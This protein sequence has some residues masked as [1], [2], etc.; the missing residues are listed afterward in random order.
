MRATSGPL[1][2]GSAA[3]TPPGAATLYPWRLA[4]TP[5][6]APAKPPVNGLVNATRQ[7]TPNQE[8]TSPDCGSSQ[9]QPAVTIRTG[10]EL[11]ETG[12]VGLAVKRFVGSS[13]IASTKI[14][15]ECWPAS[16]RLTR[17][18]SEGSGV[19]KGRPAALS[20]APSVRKRSFVIRSH[21]FH[22][23]LRPGGRLPP[24]VPFARPGMGIPAPRRRLVCVRGSTRH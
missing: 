12:L 1:M 11:A 15:D 16:S 10:C 6:A 3:P 20:L 24:A 22:Q 23:D 13:P 7:S 8:R 18:A 4:E 17:E 14:P 5:R 19:V 21:Q 9:V 2:N